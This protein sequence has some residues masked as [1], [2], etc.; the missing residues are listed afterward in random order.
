MGATDDDLDPSR[1]RLAAMSRRVPAS[2]SQIAANKPGTSLS[3]AV[4]L[5]IIL[6]RAEAGQITKRKRKVPR[7]RK[8]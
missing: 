8:R 6:G 4:I 2:H 5:A 1:E 7:R 3:M